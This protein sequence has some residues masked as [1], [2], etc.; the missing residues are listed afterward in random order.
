MLLVLLEQEG[1]RAAAFMPEHPAWAHVRATVSGC[2]YDPLNPKGRNTAEPAGLSERLR[3][4]V[5]PLLA[6][7]LRKPMVKLGHVP[8]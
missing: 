2:R 5:V 1:E 3:F 7:I 4:T 6:G 8:V